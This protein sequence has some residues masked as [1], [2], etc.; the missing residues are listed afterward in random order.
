MSLIGDE[1]ANSV[2]LT[3]SGVPVVHE[4]WE[5]YTTLLTQVAGATIFYGALM[6][7]GAWLAGP[8]RPALAV[9]RTAAPYMRHLA[10]VYGV[11][12]VLIALLFFWWS[13]TPATRNPVTGTLLAVLLLLGVEGLRRHTIREFPEADRALAARLRRERLSRLTSA[14]S[15]FASGAAG[16]V[17]T[18]T[19]AVVRQASSYA[20]AGRGSGSDERL[21]RLERVERLRTTGVLS[22][23]EARA[24]KAR[25]L[26]DEDGVD[27]PAPTG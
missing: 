6:L 8:T 3:A 26:R 17:R 11:A 2:A 20:A 5:I 25:I 10:I 9:R 21:D 23:E 7:A 4:V 13:P 19:A 1:V 12:A 18:G 14:A 27:A 15:G 24:E 16:G 22:D